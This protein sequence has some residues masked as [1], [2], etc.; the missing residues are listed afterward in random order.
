MKGVRKSVVAGLV[1]AGVLAA[2]PVLAQQSGS[3]WY[4][5]GA[6]GQSEAGGWCDD[7]GFPGV[8]ITSCDDKD[9]A[10]KA[11][12]G[13]RINRNFAVEGSYVNFGKA[14]GTVNF[15]GSSVS[16][17]AKSDGFGIAALGILPLSDQFELFGKLGFMR[18]DS[19]ADVTIGGSTFKV[20]SSGTELH[21]GVGG[22]YNLS[23]N[24]GIRAEWENVDD[25]DLSVLSIGLQYRF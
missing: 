14:R 12:V 24:L 7:P 8:S 4:V 22:I 10:Y 2:G 6:I 13:Y 17:D 11:F 23:R 3:G 20:G 18:G 15:G 19:E 25:A 21:Y 16:V 9:T 1:A 5:G